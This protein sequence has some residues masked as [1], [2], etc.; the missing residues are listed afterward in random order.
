MMT[1][2]R[3]VTLLAVALVIAAVALWLPNRRAAAP[4][5]QVGSL[6][7]PGLK[8]QLDALRSLR[9]ESRGAGVTLTRGEAGWS[10]EERDYP[11]DPV[12]LRKLLLN[13]ADLK[14]VEEKTSDASNYAR[15]GVEDPGAEA[16]SVLVEAKTP[17]ATYALLVGKV[18]D[19]HSSYVRVPGTATS[20]LASPQVAVDAD[21]KRWIDATLID[22]PADRI[23][24][25]A[26]TPA[27]G[28]AWRATR[29]AAT[30][31]LTLQDLPKGKSQ[32]S[33]G[34]VTPVAAMLTGLHIEDVASAPDAPPAGP[35]VELR[36][37]DGV[38]IELHGR[39]D[40]DQRYIRGSARSTGDAAAK[41]AAA[42]ESRLA[43]REFEVLRYKYD[44][45]FRPLAD[46]T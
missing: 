35:R 19:S 33:P 21:P 11:A 7:L 31:G 10:V 32:R 13:L 23:E 41:E 17:S 20:L 45:L 28:P 46:F 15:L 3:L 44:A 34:G 4:V 25:V 12:K 43:G 37:F 16:A 38:V 29:A 6:V 40:G 1:P 39:S 9:L 8:T 36:T 2:R 27:S 22:L 30:D 5:A 26:V 18:A 14:I 42:L 24:S